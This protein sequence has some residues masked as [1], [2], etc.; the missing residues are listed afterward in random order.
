[1]KNTLLTLAAVCA[2][3]TGAWAEPVLEISQVKAFETAPTAMAGGGF[4][5]ITNSGDTG[6]RLIDVL[7]D[8]PRVELHRTEFD[9]DGVATMI[10]LEDGIDIPPGETVT[11]APGGMHVMFMG[12][13]D[14]PFTEGDQ[15]S[16]RLVFE[17]SGEVPVTFDI[18]KRPMTGHEGADGDGHSHDHN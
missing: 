4:M 14:T 8:Y 12:L 3:T 5:E 16:A 18:I 10:H 2:L 9:S 13:R 11:L 7:A 6:D 17:T 1:M 15:V